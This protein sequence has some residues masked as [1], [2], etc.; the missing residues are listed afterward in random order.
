MHQAI[1]VSSSPT[2]CED[3]SHCLPGF[4]L[5][6]T[7]HLVSGLD[8]GVVSTAAGVLDGEQV[9]VDRWAVTRFGDVLEQKIVFGDMTER[10]AAR[11]R[12]QLAAVDGVL[13]A[14]IEHHFVRA[15]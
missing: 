12:E 7:V 3:L 11:L 9:V 10:R 14:K 6:H 1:P 15:R 5:T 2:V 8:L 4:T 13:R